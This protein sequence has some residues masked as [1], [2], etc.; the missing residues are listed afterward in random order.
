MI[1][2]EKMHEGGRYLFFV[3]L[4]AD[5]RSLETGPF[6]SRGAGNQLFLDQL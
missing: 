6:H 1:E 5:A 4:K 3:E 2:G